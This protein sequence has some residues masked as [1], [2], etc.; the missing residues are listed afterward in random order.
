[1]E[2]KKPPF[3]T[4]TN[5]LTG[6]WRVG[7]HR[8][9]LQEGTVPCHRLVTE[10]QVIVAVPDIENPVAQEKVAVVAETETAPLAGGVMVPH[11][12]AVQAAA[13]CAFH[14]AVPPEAVHWLLARLE[15]EST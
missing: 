14:V 15:S 10:S 1:V 8:A 6:F 11:E 13:V 9:A 7:V 3:V 2:G 5:P 4:V 12:T